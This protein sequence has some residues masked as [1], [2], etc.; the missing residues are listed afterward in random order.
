M[1]EV[2][3]T[4]S[5]MSSRVTARTLAAPGPTGLSSWALHC[6]ALHCTALHCTA[7][8]HLF[9]HLQCPWVVSGWVKGEQDTACVTKHDG[10]LSAADPPDGVVHQADSGPRPA[11]RQA[12]PDEGK[13]GGVSVHRHHLPVALY[14]ELVR[15]LSWWPEGSHRHCVNANICTKICGGRWAC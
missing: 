12:A 3:E 10:K 8:R 9:K 4:V 13:V 1:T 14:S 7:T 11:Q 5:R 15:H 2:A 6:S